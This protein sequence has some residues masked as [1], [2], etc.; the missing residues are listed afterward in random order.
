MLTS[1]NIAESIPND[2][3]PIDDHPEGVP[4]FLSPEKWRAVRYAEFLWHHVQPLLEHFAGSGRTDFAPYSFGPY[5]CGMGESISFTFYGPDRS[6]GVR[7]RD[8]AREQYL[9]FEVRLWAALSEGDRRV[10]SQRPSGHVPL[11]E[12]IEGDMAA[13]FAFCERLFSLL[14]QRELASAHFWRNL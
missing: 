6:M 3:L 8:S 5:P 4:V 10:Y 11:G 14:D 7:L 13:Y 2:L 12:Y 9:W 1:K